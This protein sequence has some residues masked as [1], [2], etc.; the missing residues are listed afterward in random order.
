MLTKQILRY[1]LD[2]DVSGEYRTTEAWIDTQYTVKQN[3]YFVLFCF[4]FGI[5][6]IFIDST[7]KTKKINLN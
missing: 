6:I 1:S 4:V 5:L 2:S 3:S 7:V